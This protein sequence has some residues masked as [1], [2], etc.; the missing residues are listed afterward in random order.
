MIK[1]KPTFT[2]AEPNCGSGDGARHFPPHRDFF[3]GHYS[4]KAVSEHGAAGVPE[5]TSSC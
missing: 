2:I 5:K 3:G 1:S 4:E